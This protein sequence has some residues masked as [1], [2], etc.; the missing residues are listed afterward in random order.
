[1][2]NHTFS[3][4]QK[5][6]NHKIAHFLRAKKVWSFNRTSKWANVPICVNFLKSHFFRTLKR[7]HNSSFEKGEHACEF[8]NCTFLHKKEQLHIFN[9]CSLWSAK[10]VRFQNLPFFAHFH[11]LIISKERLLCEQIFKERQNVQSHIGTFLKSDK[12]CDCTFTHF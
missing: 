7:S 1:L 12:M 5:K 3:K 11:T 10:K 2:H 4:S 9:V 6:C 8:S